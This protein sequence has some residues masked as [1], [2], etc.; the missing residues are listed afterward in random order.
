[1]RKF[2]FALIAV[3]IPALL[4]AAFA[5]DEVDNP[6]G[7]DTV[8]SPA[9]VE[10][11]TATNYDDITFWFNATGTWVNPDYTMHGTTEYSAG[12]T[13][14]VD[15]GS[16]DINTVAA[17]CSTNGLELPT[18]S[19]R[20]NYATN[21]PNI[22]PN[23]TSNP[24][25]RV[26]ARVRPDAMNGSGVIWRA[27]DTV[28]G[29]DYVWLQTYQDDDLRVYWE[30]NGGQHSCSTTGNYIAEDT[31]YT[32][33]VI[34]DE[35]SDNI[36]ILIDGVQRANCT[37]VGMADWS[38]TP[39][40]FAIGDHL[41]PTAYDTHIGQLAVSTDTTRDFHDLFVTQSTCDYPG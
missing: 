29:N 18:P 39:D 40:A 14:A 2:L 26:G 9:T 7:V 19:D 37:S 4:W 28:S 5:V 17:D 1:M 16:T 15:T 33:E 24:T 34:I 21:I 13:T 36:Q 3:L 8:S 30:D 6:A 25:W 22:F 31:W 12:D 10:G 35:P 32:M 11:V 27:A 38:T 23:A 41:G 20:H